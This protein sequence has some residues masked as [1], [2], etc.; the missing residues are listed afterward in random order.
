MGTYFRANKSPQS[1]NGKRAFDR[2]KKLP[3]L[4]LMKFNYRIRLAESSSKY[5]IIHLIQYAAGMIIN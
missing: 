2:T 1:H 5:G 3:V 4:A